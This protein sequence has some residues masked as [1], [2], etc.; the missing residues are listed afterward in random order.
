MNEMEN[1]YKKEKKSLNPQIK[2][3]FIRFSIVSLGGL[4][5]NE[6]IIFIMLK[7]LNQIAEEDLLFT[8]GKIKIEKIIISTFLAIIIVT[9]YNFVL[10]KIWTFKEKEEGIEV[11]VFT[12]FIKFSIVGASGTL[13]N[14]G[15]VYL[16]ATIMNI[17]E[18]VSTSI[19]FILSVINNYIFNEI[20]TFNVKNKNMRKI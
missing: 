8:I 14:L 15:V 1:D 20:W 2:R 12:Q 10:N 13:V 19:A 18:Y 9:I 3:R 17:N 4:A 11:N 16:L 7:I 5:I 6:L